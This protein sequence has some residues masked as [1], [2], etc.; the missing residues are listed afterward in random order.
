MKS[1]DVEPAPALVSGADVSRI[2][3]AVERLE[4]LVSNYIERAPLLRRRFD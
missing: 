3:T 2:E 4:T 1:V